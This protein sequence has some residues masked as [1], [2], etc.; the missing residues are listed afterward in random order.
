MLGFLA[1]LKDNNNRPWFA[2]HKAEYEAVQRRCMEED[3]SWKGPV[4]EYLALY[5]GLL[6]RE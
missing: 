6:E 5:Q 4:K 2:K 3:F 1:L